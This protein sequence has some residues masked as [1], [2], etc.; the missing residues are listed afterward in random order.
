MDN[1]EYNAPGTQPEESPIQEAPVYTPPYTPRKPSPF[2]DSPYEFQPPVYTPPKKAKKARSG[3]K[4]FLSALLVIVLVA[5]SCF[6]TATFLNNHW[7]SKMNTMA[8][9]FQSK[10]DALEKAMASG[11]ATTIIPGTTVS[12]AEGLTP[13]Q[14]YALNAPSVVMVRN[15]ISTSN[16]GQAAIATSTGS[17]FFLTSDGFV[18]TNH[19]VIEGNGTLSISTFDGKEYPATLIGSNNSNDVALLK[20]EGENFPAVTLGSSDAL[21]VGDQVVAIG[22]PLGELTATQ[23]VGYV[24]A[25]ERDVNT[26]GFS[27]NMIQTDAAIN[28]GNSGGPMFNMNGEVVGITTAK[29]SGNSSSGASIEGIGFAIPIDDVQDMLDDL[30]SVGYVQSA[31]LGVSISDMN[32]EAASYY[33]L[34]MGAYVVEVFPGH[35]AKA[36]GIQEKDII[37][38]VGPYEV[39]SLNTLSK[40]LRKFQAGDSTTITVYRSG[41]EIVM[42]ITL[43]EKPKD[44]G[45]EATQPESNQES[46]NPLLPENGSFEDYYNFFKD[47]FEKNGG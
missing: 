32:A 16:Y 25:K 22:N 24:S 41:K 15:R 42:D 36:A 6:G 2:A 8:N 10:L 34:P 7:E 14:V 9:S 19:H 37:L 11:S 4:R 30:M 46:N 39:T 45:T 31:Y 21:V 28:S 20:V 18:V 47:F 43:D 38:A 35:C 44:T 13:A 23:T 17:G 5:G 33:N 27:I 29:Y 40:A 3:G 1:F 12:S 26:S